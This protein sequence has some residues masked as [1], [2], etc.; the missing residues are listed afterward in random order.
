MLIVKIGEEKNNPRLCAIT[1][2]KTLVLNF[3]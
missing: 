1:K 2:P 3:K